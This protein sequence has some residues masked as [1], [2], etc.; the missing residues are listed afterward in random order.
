[1]SIVLSFKATGDCMKKYLLLIC[2]LCFLFLASCSKIMSNTTDSLKDKKGITHFEIGQ[3]YHQDNGLY[4]KLVDEG[5]YIMYDDEASI[6]KTEEDLK[7]EADKEEARQYPS[8]YFYQGHY[9]K[10]GTDLILEDK[11]EIDLLFASVANYK[12]GIY[13]RVD[14]TKSTGTVRVKYSS[15]GLYF[16]R[17]RP[18]KN[19]YHKSNKKIPNSKDDFVSQYTYDPLTRND[20]PR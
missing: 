1:M 7:N 3:T 17:P 12:K 19:Y 9:K 18:I 11:T 14:Y 2:C 16:V 10:E 13:F 20:Y 15:Q 5:T 6:Y 4:F 8:L